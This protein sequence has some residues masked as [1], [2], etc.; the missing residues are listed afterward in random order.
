MKSQNEQFQ[1]QEA[2]EADEA[3]EIQNV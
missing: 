1:T 2:H 3:E